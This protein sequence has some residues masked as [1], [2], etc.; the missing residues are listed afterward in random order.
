MGVDAVAQEPQRGTEEHDFKAF[1]SEVT[2]GD[3][4]LQSRLLGAIYDD[5]KDYCAHPPDFQWSMMPEPL[6]QEVLSSLHLELAGVQLIFRHGARDLTSDQQC[7]NPMNESF[8]HCH[9]ASMVAFAKI[10]SDSDAPFLPLVKQVMDAYPSAMKP[11]KVGCGLGEL[12][13]EAKPMTKAFGKAL[14][15]TYFNSLPRYPGVQDMRFYAGDEQRTLGT[16]YYILEQLFPNG[17][18]SG[19]L[20]PLFTRPPASDPWSRNVPCDRANAFLGSLDYKDPALVEH[21]F[22]SFAARWRRAAGTEFQANFKDCLNVAKCS[23]QQGL[24]LPM[25]LEVDS[26]LFQESLRVSLAVYHRNFLKDVRAQQLL[27]APALFEVEDYLMR[28][29]ADDGPLVAFWSSHD[30]TIMTLLVALGIWD[31][32]WPPYTDAMILEVY[33]SK[34]NK[35]QAFFR[36]LRGGRALALPWCH[37]TEMRWSGLCDVQQFLPPEVKVL[38]NARIYDAECAR[39]SDLEVHNT[40]SNLEK[41]RTVHVSIF[42]TWPSS[43][44]STWMLSNL[45][46]CTIGCMAGYVMRDLKRR[47]NGLPRPESGVR[48]AL[49]GV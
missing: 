1:L 3:S 22:P 16:L 45:L 10:N 26:A 33:R 38:R 9:L 35:S 13:D 20:I 7:F 2:R 25:G 48:E 11:S 21:W 37:D 18:E 49:L 47:L 15:A 30:L 39:T 43:L 29:V 34:D 17:T 31:G 41:S 23:A 12:L 19:D 4:E 46:F 6:P 40:T 36:W 27:A 32:T 5:F 24:K 44:A 42:A 14:Q 28:L 8:K